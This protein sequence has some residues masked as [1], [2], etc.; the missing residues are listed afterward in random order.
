MALN[1]SSQMWAVGVESRLATRALAGE[2]ARAGGDV[3]L[4]RFG[5]HESGLAKSIRQLRFVNHYAAQAGEFGMAAFVNSIWP[6]LILW[7]PSKA[8]S[9]LAL[10]RFW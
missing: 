2:L 7:P 6:T 3:F 9:S 5:I 10:L 1:L 8:D 4:I